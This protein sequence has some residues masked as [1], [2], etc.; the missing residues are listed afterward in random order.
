[1]TKN[2]GSYNLYQCRRTV[3]YGSQ[4]GPNMGSN[5]R[6]TQVLDKMV[7]IIHTI[8]FLTRLIPLMSVIYCFVPY[9]V[10]YYVL[11]YYAIM[12]LLW[13]PWVHELYALPKMVLKTVIAFAMNLTHILTDSIFPHYIL[14]LKILYYVYLTS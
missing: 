7:S 14:P 5:H 3:S 6:E 2:T 13:E 1:M 9:D 11:I 10:L 4:I 8:V 12:L